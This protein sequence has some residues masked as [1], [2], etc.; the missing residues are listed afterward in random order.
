MDGAGRRFGAEKFCLFNRKKIYRYRYR[1][2]VGALKPTEPTFTQTDRTSPVQLPYAVC[3][4]IE[5]IYLFPNFIAIL[6]GALDRFSWLWT[7]ANAKKVSVGQNPQGLAVLHHVVV[8]LA[9]RLVL[10][11]EPFADQLR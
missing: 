1:Y 8:D 5:Q 3:I 9:Q 10:E 11:L 6:F 7:E 4:E 2:F